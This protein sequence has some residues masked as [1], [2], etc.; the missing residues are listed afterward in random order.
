MRWLAERGRGFPVGSRVVP[1]V[2]AAVIFDLSYGTAS[3]PGSEDGYRACESAGSEVGEGSVGAGTG[4]TVG[5]A[6]GIGN[7]MKGGIGTWSVRHGDLV[8]GCIAVVNAFGDVRDASGVILAGARSES[9]LVDARKYLADGGEPGGSFATAGANTTLV[10]VATNGGLSRV[11]LQGVAEMACDA[12]AQR[13]TPFGT[14]FDGDIVFAASAGE[15]P[16]EVPLMME[17]LAQE[18]TATVVE[19]A[20]RFAVGNDEVPG[21]GGSYG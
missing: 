10:V 15:V 5:K 13:I 16:V 17:L 19:R 20:V 1:I 14:S 6:L 7:A 11:Q 18:A 4:A 2:P 12:L 21:I 9:G 3:W 8:I